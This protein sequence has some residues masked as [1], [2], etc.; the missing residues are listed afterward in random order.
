MLQA[1]REW[2][3]KLMRLLCCAY[4][5]WAE[6]ESATSSSP[7]TTLRNVFISAISARGGA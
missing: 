5:V 2:M 1:V 7:K 3:E 4:A 6:G